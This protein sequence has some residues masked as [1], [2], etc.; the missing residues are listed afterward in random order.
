M[1][2]KASFE[3]SQQC[4]KQQ[5][6][7][8][9]VN[10]GPERD[11]LI[12]GPKRGESGQRTNL[13]RARGERTREVILEEATALFSVYGYRGT[14]L[15]D[16]SERVGISHPG[17]LHHFAHKDALLLA[18][19]ER[20]YQYFEELIDG[21]AAIAQDPALVAKW[22]TYRQ[23]QSLMFAVVR[24]E[25][26]EPSHPARQI[27][28]D[29]QV[30]ME[31]KLEAVFEEY[32]RKGWLQEGVTPKWCARS[33]VAMWMGVYMRDGLFQDTMFDHDLGVFLR[34]LLIPLREYE[35]SAPGHIGGTE[36]EA[37]SNEHKP[38]SRT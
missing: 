25:A 13:T 1:W 34:L 7:C 35:P 19:M 27:V 26:I 3:A 22:D 11:R 36:N 20:V 28:I 16:I 5:G 33:V 38:I 30:M 9:Q 21:F 6:A 10:L 17:M 24:A 37:S 29:M 32:E 4:D 8:K 12:V 23:Y 31:T 18:V 2:G 14:S 15:R